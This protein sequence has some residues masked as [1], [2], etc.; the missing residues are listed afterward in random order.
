MPSAFLIIS[1]AVPCT[2][3]LYLPDNPEFC[4]YKCFLPANVLDTLGV[5]CFIIVCQ[6]KTP[7]Y[8]S[9]KKGEITLA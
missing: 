6:S 4:P 9:K 2:G 1:A 5:F 3:V 8:P 7:L